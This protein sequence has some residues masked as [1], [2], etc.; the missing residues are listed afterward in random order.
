MLLRD[1]SPGRKEGARTAVG[2]DQKSLAPACCNFVDRG[3][4]LGAVRIGVVHVGYPLA[5]GRV[6]R[7]EVVHG[8]VGEGEGPPAGCLYRAD[9]GVLGPRVL[10]CVGYL[11]AVGRV[12][13]VVVVG[14]VV[15]DVEP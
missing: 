11:L 3:S 9:L 8:V 2:G 15:G 12:V 5:V 6:G 14:I 13:G 10:G 4:S 7:R 1:A